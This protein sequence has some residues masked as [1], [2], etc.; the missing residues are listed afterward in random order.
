MLADEFG[1][2]QVFWSMLWFF[3]FALWLWLVFVIFADIFRSPDL[4]GW[5]KAAWTIFV[6]FLPYL[7]VFTYLIVRGPRMS[8]RAMDDARRRDEAF[9]GY[10]K[11]VVASTSTTTTTSAGVDQL[12]QLTALHDSGVIDDEEFRQMKS[13][14]TAV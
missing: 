8:E 14:L 12:S 10:V 11:D 4:S 5:G 13:R 9:R 6:I 7:G 2:G 3:L 1:T